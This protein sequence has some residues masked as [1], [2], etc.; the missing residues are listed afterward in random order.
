MCAHS[1][2]SE[3]QMAKSIKLFKTPIETVSFGLRTSKT[4]RDR[5]DQ[6]VID[7]KFPNRN[8]WIIKALEHFLG[9][10]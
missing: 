4:L 2:N 5:I 7:C 6:D 3:I 8:Q 9:D 10:C 1:L